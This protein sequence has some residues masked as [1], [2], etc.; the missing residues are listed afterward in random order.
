MNQPQEISALIAF[1]AG[2]LS[3]VSPCVLPLVPSYIT[4]VTG[5]SFKELADAR[6]KARLRWATMI[7]SLL[8]IMGFSAVFILIGASASYLG[9]V[10]VEYQSWIMKGGGVLII[11]LGIHFT[12]VINIPFLLLE[13]RFE[14]RKKPLGYLGSFFVGV[15]FAA[16]WTPCI[17]PILSTILIYASTAKNYTTGVYL[18]TAYS[19]GLGIPFFLSSLAFNAFLSAFDRIK[20]YM[21]WITL[22]SGIFLIII[23]ILFLTDTFR[24][25]NAF[26]NMLANP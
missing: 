6:G 1:T 24:E 5:V 12:G 10:L 7:H 15:V 23:G 14:F 2:I 9:Q 19:M 20:R 17:G 18:L 25:I 4:Y 22:I 3:F 8:F 26:F 21:R 13:K 11:V 16:G